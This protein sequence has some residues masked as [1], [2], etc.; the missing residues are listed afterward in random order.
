M[1]A[2]ALL[3]LLSLATCGSD[4]DKRTTPQEG[5]VTAKAIADVDGAMADAQKA[6]P[7]T[8]APSDAKVDVSAK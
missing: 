5:K 6:K 1:R 4:P 3:A 7:L 2:F 8:V